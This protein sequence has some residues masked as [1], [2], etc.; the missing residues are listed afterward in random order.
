ML[1]HMLVYDWSNAEDMFS[2]YT[3]SKG[4]K[5]EGMGMRINCKSQLAA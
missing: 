2:A 1:L 3:F 4:A 5:N